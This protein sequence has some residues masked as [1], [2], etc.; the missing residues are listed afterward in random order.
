MECL[1]VKVC[2]NFHDQ[3]SQI[4]FDWLNSRG[5]PVSTDHR[6]ISMGKHP[7]ETISYKGGSS[8]KPT[9]F[10][11]VNV[12]VSVIRAIVRHFPHHGVL[13]P[14][15]QLSFRFPPELRFH[16]ENNVPH[17]SPGDFQYTKGIDHK[18]SRTYRV[19]CSALELK[20]NSRNSSLT[21][22]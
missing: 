15:L 18:F 16:V 12:R 8:M 19:C 17:E 10:I 7:P 14:A 22:F 13:S 11:L 2:R 9:V 6:I 3:D 21:A 5:D 4:R 20:K 1:S